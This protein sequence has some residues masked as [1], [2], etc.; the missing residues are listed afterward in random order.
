M[1]KGANSTARSAQVANAVAA[2][3]AGV[4]L[5]NT[6]TNS[7][8]TTTITITPAQPSIPIAGGGRAHLDWIKELLAAG[9]LTL[10]MVTNSYVNHPRTNVIGIRKAIG[11]PTGTAAEVAR[12]VGHW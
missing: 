3:A 11:D 2:G 9:P 10:R 12:Y 4:I 1:D 7:A 5:G 8:P 6:A